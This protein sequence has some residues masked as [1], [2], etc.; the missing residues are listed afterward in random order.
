LSSHEADELWYS[1]LKLL[2]SSKLSKDFSNVYIPSTD[3]PV[4]EMIV[5]FS[6][7]SSHTVIMKYKPAP[8]GYKI[9]AL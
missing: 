9:Y 4:D 2:L 5:R 1:K 8:K 7:R 6:G 3:I